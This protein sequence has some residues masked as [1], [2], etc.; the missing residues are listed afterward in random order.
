[1]KEA[2]LKIGNISLHEIKEE[3]SE[4]WCQRA[5]VGILAVPLIFFVT[6]GQSL[7]CSVPQFLIGKMKITIAPTS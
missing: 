5:A 2:L 7:N 3:I 1:M 6:L 4:P